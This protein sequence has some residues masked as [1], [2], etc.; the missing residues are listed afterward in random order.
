MK[1]TVLNSGSH[2][3]GYVLQ[4]DTEAIIIECGCHIQEVLEALDFNTRK[5]VGVFVSHAHLDH[6]R[7]IEDY[8]NYFP[9]YCSAGAINDFHFKKQRRPFAME[10][11]KT[12]QFGSFSVRPFDTEH[13]CSEPIG[14][15]IKHP[16]IGT[17]LFATDTYYVKYQ[18]VEL[19]NMMIE[20]NYDLKILQENV[21]LGTI[22]RRLEERTLESHMSL[23]HCKQMLRST[24]LTRVN[25]IILLH[26]SKNNA[27]PDRFR[28][29]IELLT[30]KK[31]YIA[32]RGLELPIDVTPFA[33]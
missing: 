7:Y 11:L 31:V 30:G 4:N 27:E 15:L 1:L 13:D 24:D 5:V 12:V 17:L 22:P 3:N 21:G 16:E 20:C 25:N 29:E 14:F 8:L 32:E 23:E 28:K 6:M 33:L 10:P 9:C 26:L 19:T 2:A 18:F